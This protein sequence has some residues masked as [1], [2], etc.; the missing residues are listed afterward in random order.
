M[1][2]SPAS[3]QTSATG[4]SR[5]DADINGYY[6]NTTDR[7]YFDY[8][9]ASDLKYCMQGG[10]L[11]A[12]VG[13]WGETQWQELADRIGVTY[14][15]TQFG[16]AAAPYDNDPNGAVIV[17]VEDENAR[18]LQAYLNDIDLWPRPDPPLTA[19]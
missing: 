12:P 18:A 8:V 3:S 14:L 11:A 19:T 2:K 17:G 13:Q 9:L 5:A 7:F 4:Q 6:G 15:G 16:R 1:R 10:D